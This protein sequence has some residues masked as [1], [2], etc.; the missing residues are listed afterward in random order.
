MEQ[1]GHAGKAS[2]DFRSHDLA[3]AIT[4]V[5][6]LLEAILKR[7]RNNERKKGSLL[8]MPDL[9]SYGSL[10][11][12]SYGSLTKNGDDDVVE[13]EGNGRA[14]AAATAFQDGDTYYLKDSA[15]LSIKKVVLSAVPILG[16]VLLMGG[17]V[18]F[19]LRDFGRLYP[20]RGGDRN[21][22]PDDYHPRTSPVVVVHSSSLDS[23]TD[24][25]ESSARH[26]SKD[27]SKES[28]SSS[29]VECTAHP[30]CAGLIGQC[31]P[32]L[33]GIQLECCN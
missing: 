18:L 7:S 3:A 10:S 8:K 21:P 11:K 16:A 27:V 2:F 26:H 23:N 33:D 20:G 24:G 32:T 14:A 9:P 17:I 28:S 13:E 29:S 12:N 15:P 1:N 4:P 22:L 30:N 6:L 31:C 19:L 25:D 5:L